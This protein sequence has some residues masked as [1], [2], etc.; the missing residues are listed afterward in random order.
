MPKTTD[1][2]TENSTAALKWESSRVIRLFRSR[3]FSDGNVVGIGYADEIQ[4]SCDDQKLGAIIGGGVGNCAVS[5]VLY[6]RH[7][8]KSAR[9][10]VTDKSQNVQDVA[11]VGQVDSPLHHQSQHKHDADRRHEQRAANP[12]LL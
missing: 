3:L 1:A 11:S 5:P 7:D 12:A 9:T 10:H 6:A 8:V 4:Q 2:N